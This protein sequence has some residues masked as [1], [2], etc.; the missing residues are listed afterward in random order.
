MRVVRPADMV[1]LLADPGSALRRMA[2]SGEVRRIARGIYVAV[3]D[4]AYDPKRW[5]PAFEAAAG[6]IGTALFGEG[7]AVAMGITAARLHRA[8]PRACARA[9]V[10]VERGRAEV[11]MAD[12][13]HGWVTFVQRELDALDVQPIRTELGTFLAT[14]PEQTLIDLATGSDLNPS[15]ARETMTILAQSVDWARVAALARGLAD[16]RSVL[17][18]GNLPTA[19]RL[20]AGA[21][22]GFDDLV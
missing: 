15:D 10:A 6:A 18:D 3:P 20:A 22:F 9:Y 1:D 21:A 14:T 2:A 7:R 19:D 16:V 13:D 5:R 11:R 8:V 12:R 4:D 17:V